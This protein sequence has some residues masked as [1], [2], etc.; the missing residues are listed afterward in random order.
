MAKLKKPLVKKMQSGGKATPDSTKFYQDKLKGLSTTS[1]R[2]SAAANIINSNKKDEN[3][4]ERQKTKYDLLRQYRKG[5]SGFDANGNPL[6]KQKMGGAV[7]K[8][9][10]GGKIEEQY[11]KQKK[12]TSKQAEMDNIKTPYPKTIP[13]GNSSKSKTL[14]DVYSIGKRNSALAL[15]QEKEN[16]K[17]KERSVKPEIGTYKKGGVIKKTT[18]PVAKKVVKLIKKKK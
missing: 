1:P 12:V 3:F 16:A 11:Q 6:K 5:K 17:R 7:K 18:K 14:S 15:A 2:W 9:Q 4:A 13:K 10:T 8:M